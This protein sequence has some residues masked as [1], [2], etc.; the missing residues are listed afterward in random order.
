MKKLRVGVIGCGMISDTYI[1]NCKNIFKNIEIV[2]CADLAEEKSAEKA[3][4]YGI[5]NTSAEALIADDGI[6]AVLNLT[7]PA[8]HYEISK[9]S[10]EAGKHVYCEKPLALN[11]TEGLALTELAAEKG[12]RIGCAPDTFLG[13]GLQ[14]A[15]KLIDNGC[16]GKPIGVNAAFLSVGP[17]AV[18]SAP[19]FFYQK[20]GGPLFDMGPYYITAL[21]SLFGAVN[22][23]IGVA[24][25]T[26]PERKILTP[27]RYGEA[28]PVETP[29]HI[30]S[31][32]DFDCGVTATLTTSFDTVYPYM[33]SI[34]IYGSEG[35]LSVPDPNKFGGPV[36][37]RRGGELTEVP[38]IGDLTEN[39]RGLGL[40]DM[41]DSIINN[42]QAR[43]DGG[44][45]LHVLEVMSGILDS[46]ETGAL[47]HMQYKCDRPQRFVNNF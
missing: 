42:R 5:K 38:L 12:L 47:R 2:S 15:A 39:L 1:N 18:H 24:K 32:L 41:A 4:E 37:I 20:G 31:V 35:S 45:A 43:A 25:T 29:T 22:G 28:F 44:L 30:V 21:I 27:E 19:E 6:D 16:I 17:E 9:K 13:S 26:Y 8:A 36:K 3:A 40:S 33:S 10:L 11:A 14:T 23:V 7:I 46:G 34:E